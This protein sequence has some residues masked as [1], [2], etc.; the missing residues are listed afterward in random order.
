MRLAHTL[1]AVVGA[2]ALSGQSDG[3]PV[4]AVAHQAP[5]PV[6]HGADACLPIKF[7]D[8]LPVIPAS[9]AGRSITLGFDTGAPGILHL[10]K[11]LVDELKLT[12]IGQSRA[13]DPSGRNVLTL[14]L[15][16]IQG[17]KLGQFSIDRWVASGDTPSPNR[18]ANPDGIIGLTAFQ[19]Y[20]VTIDYPGRRLLITKG[21]LPAPDGTSSFHYDG[22]IPRVPLNIDGHS[23]EAH[24]DSGNSR[25]ALIVPE[26]FAARLP[27]YGERFPIGTAHT[28]NNKYDLV[29]L[30][31]H[32]ARIGKFP[33]YAGTVAFPGPSETGNVGSQILRDMIVRIDP[34]NSI[35]S[36]E[37]AKPGL[38]EGCPKA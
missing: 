38:E 13:T 36:F 9:I 3:P 18:F 25:Y 27:N 7:A 30:P 35:I 19:G 34:E 12:Q 31:I 14:S 6:V 37:R 11:P 21:G 22:P 10:N 1:L 5:N 20:T 16:A 4:G 2:A 24:I 23:L 28:V 32:D 26:G 29:A 15:Y 8:G 17:L 33:L